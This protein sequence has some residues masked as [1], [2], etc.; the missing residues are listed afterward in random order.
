MFEREIWKDIKNYDGLYQVSNLGRIKRIRFTNGK[1]DFPKEKILSPNKNKKCKYLG[2]DLHKNGK[3][4]RFLVHRLVAEAFIPN[5][6]NLF[7][8]NHKDENKLNNNINNLEWCTRKYNMNYG[9]QVER[10]HKKQRKKVNQY[11]LK[12]NYIKTW[13]SFEQIRKR[14]NI[15]NASNCCRGIYKQSNGYIWKYADDNN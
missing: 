2:V 14:L 7:E 5:P 11:D 6:N 15:T 8:V 3:R 13:D 1:Y 10:A 4:K 9:T 12:G